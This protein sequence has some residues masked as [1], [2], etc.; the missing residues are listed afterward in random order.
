MNAPTVSVVI[1]Q[2]DHR[3]QTSDSLASFSRQTLG[4]EAV[5][6]VVA[7]N[8]T[9]PELEQMVATQFPN[10]RQVSTDSSNIC[11]L[12]N[13]AAIAATGKYIFITEM[14]VT[15]DDDCLEELVQFMEEHD[16]DCA[17]VAS[18]GINANRFAACEQRI[19][20][21]D[22]NRWKGT[23]R[24][25]VTI[26][27]FMLKRSLW[28]QAG[29]FRRE[30]NHFA[31]IMLGRRLRALGASFGYC[32][33][34]IVHH[35]NQPDPSHLADELVAY[36]S[37]EMCAK[38]QEPQSDPF[39]LSMT[40]QIKPRST[41]KGVLL[42]ARRALTA[43]QMSTCKA[44][45]QYA[46]LPGEAYYSLY[47]KYWRT[48]IRLGRLNYLATHDSRSVKSSELVPFR[49]AATQRRVA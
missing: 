30:Y 18:K 40:P 42:A 32:D 48:C 33:T 39:I 20:Q 34:A 15:A 26:R 1:P 37:G 16:V 19:M 13:A 11:S 25:K 41:E 14:H 23:P 21:N 38:F 8:D 45:L 43:M 24:G 35:F 4:A 49:P 7:S 3:D 44:L 29:G 46:P 10:V 12:Y 17:C 36:G 28:R 5:E 6:I 2:I 22:L 9:E 31:E 47:R 27:G